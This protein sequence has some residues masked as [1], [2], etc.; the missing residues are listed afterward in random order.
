MRID[1]AMTSDEL[2]TARVSQAFF[3]RLVEI[4]PTRVSQLIK[5]G[6]LSADGDGVLLLVSLKKFFE[7]QAQKGC[8]SVER[9]VARHTE[10]S[11][12]NDTT[13]GETISGRGN[14]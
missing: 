7:Y 13:D 2:K 9:F 10:R 8:D 14:R 1:R 11:D 3:G 12:R 4:T 6:L 5:A